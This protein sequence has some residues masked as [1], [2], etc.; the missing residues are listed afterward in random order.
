MIYSFVLTEVN[1]N[2]P[3]L[4]SFNFSGLKNLMLPSFNPSIT[5]LYGCAAEGKQIIAHVCDATN[6]FSIYHLSI[7]ADTLLSLPHSDLP[8][9]MVQS[10]K[11]NI[12]LALFP[13]DCTHKNG[14]LNLKNILVFYT[15]LQLLLWKRI[16]HSHAAPVRQKD[17]GELQSL[18]LC[19]PH[20]LLLTTESTQSFL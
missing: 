2:S 7:T 15:P 14:N 18:S 1:S 17:R 16:L 6:P 19:S 12:C 10:L 3:Y 9:Y 4:G 8:S 5:W 13:D 11:N 20:G